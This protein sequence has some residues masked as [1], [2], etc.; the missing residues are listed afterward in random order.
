MASQPWYQG[1]TLPAL[2]W[3]VNTDSGNEN[4]TGVPVGNIVLIMKNTS[5]SPSQETTG[6]GTF[7]IVT[8]NPAQITYQF[9]AQDVS[10]PGNYQLQ[11]KIT[12]PAGTAGGGAA[13]GVKLYDAFPFVVTQV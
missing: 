10:N 13:G 6:T 12:F 1:Q 9:S 5:I 3:P 11:L 4:L 8:A 2:S 7:A